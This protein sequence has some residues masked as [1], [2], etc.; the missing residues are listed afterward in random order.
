MPRQLRADIVGAFAAACDQVKGHRAGAPNLV[1]DVMRLIDGALRFLDQ[2]RDIWDARRAVLERLESATL[3]MDQEMG[4]DVLAP[5]QGRSHR[6]VQTACA[7]AV[8]AIN[9][10]Q[11]Q[12][13]AH[14]RVNDA[15]DRVGLGKAGA[16]L[17]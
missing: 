8:E 5:V 9:H 1:E 14:G 12:V 15:G 3:L 10:L 16:L 13:L 6:A 17:R 2:D 7:H 4:R 11:A